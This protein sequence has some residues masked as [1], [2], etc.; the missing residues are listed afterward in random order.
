MIRTIIITLLCCVA[1]GLLR[2]PVENHV[3][4]REYDARLLPPPLTADTENALGQQMAFVSLGGLRSLVAA[5]MHI[6]AITFFM[7]KDWPGLEKRYRQVVSLAPQNAAYW[8][9]ASWHMAYNA[10]TDTMEDTN[11]TMEQRLLGYKRYISKGKWFL[12]QGIKANPDN[13]R[14]YERKGALLSGRP[15]SIDFA[16]AAEAYRKAF[17]LTNDP[18]LRRLEFYSL[19]REPGQS[20]E[21]WKLGREL[22][23]DKRNHNT[24][25][26]SILFAL[27]NK[28]N[29]PQ[30][31]RVPFNVLFPTTE[32]ARNALSLQL[33]NG[34]GYPVDGVKEALEALPPDSEG[35]KK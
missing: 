29:I 3:M 9:T 31:Q 11:L 15:R 5:M 1:F 28:L 19:V 17:E 32:I 4:K 33:S 26:D 27:E 6:D 35:D 7:S 24:S 22:F 21:A 12:D 16:A 13:W 34:L 8:D 14:L 18:L 23:K 2:M 20:R 30:D 25:L 10:A